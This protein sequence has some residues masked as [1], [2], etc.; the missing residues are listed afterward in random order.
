MPEQFH[1]IKRLPPY[2]FSIIDEIK[3]NA[4]RKGDDIIDLGMGNPD[5]PTPVEIVEKLKEAVDNPKNHRYSVSRGIYKLR[6][7][8]VNLYKRKFNIDLDPDE[9]AIVTIG[10]KE[11]LSHLALSIIE[12]GDVALVPSPTYPIHSF[13]IVIAGG[14]LKS[15]KLS[16]DSDFFENLKQAYHES[17]PHPK[18]LLLSFPHNPTT[19]TVDLDF[20][21]KIVA[22]AK[23]REIF[24]IHDYA[25][26][27]LTFGDYK[28]PS[29]LQIKGAKDIGVELYTM[30]KGYSMPGWR[31][32]FCVGN[33]KVIK[34]LG[35]LKSYFDYGI[36]QPIQIAAIIALN[37]L[38]HTSQNIRD[39]YESRCET[40]VTGLNRI[41]W[42]VE[43]PKG[44]MFLWAEIPDEFKKMGSLEFSKKILTEG[45][46]AL[47]PGIGFGPYGE[48]YIRFA[49]V[50]N[51]HRIRQAVRGIKR[52]LGNI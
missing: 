40:L 20:F 42:N 13:C 32:A 6:L 30:S 4:R 12:P 24:I 33:S 52:A 31:V 28:A 49:L 37:E 7:A 27:D 45:K 29:L 18:I 44:T 3:L 48:G 25:Y 23:E 34:A 41:G 15:V 17:W 46:V 50:E 2:V 14:N 16:R 21:E 8:I 11:G 43:K 9:E 5:I 19:A 26:A 36:F 35:R 22:F 1:R 51:E 38:G 10:A 39:I 47:S